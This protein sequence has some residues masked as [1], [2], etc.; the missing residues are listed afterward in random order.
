MS[1]DGRYIAIELPNRTL[2]GPVVVW[3][4][5]ERVDTTRE[6][7]ARERIAQ[8]DPQDVPAVPG[9]PRP[10]TPIAALRPSRWARVP[11]AALLRRH[12]AS[13]R[14]P[15]RPVRRRRVPC[16]SVRVELPHRRAAPHHAR[17]GIRDADP[18][19]DGRAAV[20]V[21]CENGLCD[22]VRVDLATGAVVV[23]RRSTPS[24]P[25][26]RPRVAPDGRSAVVAAKHD[27]RWRLALVPTDGVAADGDG[28][29]ALTLLDPDDG[30]NRYDPAFL[31][32]GRG[33]VFV[34]DAGGIPNLEMMLFADR[35]TTRLTRV[36]S[37]AF[38]PAVSRADTS[39]Y[40]LALHAR[41]LDLRRVSLASGGVGP[42][43]ALAASLAP[44]VPLAPVTV[45]TFARAR[46]ALAAPIRRWSAPSSRV[47]GRQLLHGRRI[48]DRCRS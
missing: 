2:P 46:A 44:A 39:A 33:I 37:A 1:V 21:R 26:Q 3:R 31:P 29:E 12:D 24:T 23:L 35:S 25:F 13:P 15:R 42:A 36:A 38:A 45:D 34:S 28:G 14:Q 9:D 22:L 11:L 5:V 40:F 16:G 20:G 27:G 47:A 18:L 6:R 7:R 41:G 19:P 10:K 48:R 43:V 17:G 8:L 30:A 32:D 4:T